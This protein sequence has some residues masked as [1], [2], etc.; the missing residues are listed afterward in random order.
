MR[1]RSGSASSCRPGLRLVRFDPAWRRLSSA[2][3]AGHRATNRFSDGF[4]LLVLSSA[5]LAELNERL[6]AAGHEAVGIERFAPTS[7]WR[8]RVA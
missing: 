7:C 2:V 8:H 4:P 1:R 3:D 6:Q 5:S